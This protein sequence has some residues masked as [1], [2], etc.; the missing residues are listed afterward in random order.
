MSCASYAVRVSLL[1]IASG[2][3][4]FAQTSAELRT[5][6]TET[7][8]EAGPT[9]PRRGGKRAGADALRRG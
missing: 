9:A 1:F 5:S 4:A 6:D 8:L 7:A 3:S 2:L